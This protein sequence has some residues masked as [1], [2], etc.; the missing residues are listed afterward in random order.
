MNVFHA[1]WSQLV[2]L[3]T[4][5]KM[6]LPRTSSSS[7]RKWEVCSFYLSFSFYLWQLVTVKIWTVAQKKARP[8][9][10]V[11]SKPTGDPNAKKVSVGWSNNYYCVHVQKIRN[12]ADRR[13]PETVDVIWHRQ[14]YFTTPLMYMT[15]GWTFDPGQNCETAYVTWHSLR[16]MT[17]ND[18]DYK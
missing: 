15:E 12:M 7:R 10:K 5:C 16:K 13:W 3:S 8:A 11:A 1:D 17:L 14:W 2:T 18:T 6:H 9:S 4:K